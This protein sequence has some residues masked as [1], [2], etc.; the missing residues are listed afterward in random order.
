MHVFVL[1]LSFSDF[2]LQAFKVHCVGRTVRNC[3]LFQKLCSWRFEGCS[4]S[5]NCWSASPLP[6][7][8]SQ[9][10]IHDCLHIFMCTVDTP[11][12]PLVNQLVPV[13]FHSKAFFFFFPVG[14]CEH[15]TRKVGSKCYAK[16]LA[17][18]LQQP[19]NS[20]SLYKRSILSMKTP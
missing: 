15:S 16:S 4:E 1:V 5:I 20:T 7:T 19:P 2:I 17:S 3:Y 18:L 14:G 13:E 11:W 12:T 9:S 8:L 6:P 10:M